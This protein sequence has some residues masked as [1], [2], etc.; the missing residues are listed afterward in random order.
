MGENI[1]VGQG[2]IC[3]IRKSKRARKLSL[4]LYPDGRL[5]L[6][7]PLFVSYAGGRAFLASKADW[8]EEKMT[9]LRSRPDTFLLRGG[10]EEYAVS[11]DPAR[12]LIEGRLLHF[13][14]SY[15]V[16]W[17][18]VA[19]RNQKTRFGSC[20]RGGTL[21]FNYRL[22]FLPPHLSDYVIV[23]E[24]CHLIEFNHSKKFWALVGQAIPNY[25]LLRSELRLL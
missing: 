1:D 6:T 19:I 8:I 5:F 18:R 3:T 22:L 13:Q 4:T 21:S 11:R 24:L 10:K 15:G 25:P 2:R 23:H 20:S 16:S 14:P 17:Q 9:S 7:L 12:K